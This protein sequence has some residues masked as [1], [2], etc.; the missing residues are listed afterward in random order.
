MQF[1]GIDVV[2]VFVPAASAA[3][4]P[5]TANDNAAVNPIP[6]RKPRRMISR[7]VVFC[8]LMADSSRRLDAHAP[9]D[10]ILPAARCRHISEITHSTNSKLFEAPT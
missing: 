1:G 6:D 7:R 2:R 4:D 10:L 9:N 3:A 8:S 5:A